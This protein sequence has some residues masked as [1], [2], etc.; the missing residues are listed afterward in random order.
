MAETWEHVGERTEMPT[1]LRLAEARQRGFVPRSADLVAAAVVAA[2][3]A[4]AAVL[5]GGSVDAM[6]RLTAAMLAE[7]GRVSASWSGEVSSAAWA[8][9]ARTAGLLAV[10]TV[11]AV[12][13]NVV[14][15][16]LLFSGEAVRLDLG[17]LSPVAGLGRMFSARAA[18]RAAMAIAKVL[19]A[20]GVV[21]MTVWAMVSHAAGAGEQ[22]AARVGEWIGWRVAWV[23]GWVAGALLVA[24]LVDL[25]YQRW[26]YLQDLKMT[27]REFLQDLRQI[28]GGKRRRRRRAGVEHL[29]GLPGPHAAE[30][31]GRGV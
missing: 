15:F 21:W 4:A 8:L 23:A 26:Q 6:R 2:G 31:V 25:V 29:R 5:A 16:G 19:A 11:M 13:A 14:Q 22:P 3:V 20:A 24:A 7:A 10:V 12:V 1:A 9:A 30:D 17:R 27:R 28:E 18:V